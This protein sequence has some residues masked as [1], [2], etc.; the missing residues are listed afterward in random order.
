MFFTIWYFCILWLILPI[1]WVHLTRIFVE[2]NPSVTDV[3]HCRFIA[4]RNLRKSIKPIVLQWNKFRWW[5]ASCEG[6]LTATVHKWAA[7]TCATT[8]VCKCVYHHDTWIWIKKS[9]SKPPFT[10]QLQP[11]W[12][13]KLLKIRATTFLFQKNPNTRWFLRKITAWFRTLTT[14]HEFNNR[15]SDGGFAWNQSN[16]AITDRKFLLD[17]ECQK[18]SSLIILFQ[19]VTN[20]T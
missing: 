1:R 3:A 14:P 17:P 16:V 18:Y 8:V 13:A 9:R 20:E 11:A 19:I 7:A 12:H 15:L 4:R 6:Y 10:L 2:R 5:R